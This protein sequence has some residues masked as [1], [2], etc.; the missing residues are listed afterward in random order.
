MNLSQ[1]RI[2][3]FW[4]IFSV[5][6]MEMRYEEMVTDTEPVI[7]EACSFLGIDYSPGMMETIRAPRGTKISCKGYAVSRNERI[8]EGCAEP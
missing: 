4:Q 6:H 8:T 2:H 7:R 3:S 1:I 5:Y